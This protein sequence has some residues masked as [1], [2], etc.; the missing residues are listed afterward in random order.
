MGH[1][2]GRGSLKDGKSNGNYIGSYN[3]NSNS[4]SR[5]FR[6]AAE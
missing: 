6:Y 5:F 1:P 2:V 4:N 3:S